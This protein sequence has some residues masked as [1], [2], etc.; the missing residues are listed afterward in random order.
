MEKGTFKK[1]DRTNA[2]TGPHAGI[3]VQVPVNKKRGTTIGI[4]YSYRATDPFKGVHSIGARIN[5]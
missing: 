1:A 3:T 4:D 5:L 2:L